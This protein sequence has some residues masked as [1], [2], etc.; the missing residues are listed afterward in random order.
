MTKRFGRLLTVAIAASLLTLASISVLITVRGIGP[1]QSLSVANCQPEHPTST[2]VQ[3][4]LN[5]NGGMMGGSAMMV[6]LNANVATVASGRVTFIATN[7]G[8]LNH[9]LLILPMPTGGAGTRP[10]GANGKIDE[11]SSLGEASQS[12]ATGVGNGISPGTR[13]WTTVNLVP[14]N[15]ELLCD[16]P[17]H[18]AN[19]MF[20][21]LTVR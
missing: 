17:W 16:V 11:S 13:S 8:H 15:Y 2:P 6:G 21:T 19:G 9:E 20:T 4:S 3:V 18:Y 10:L 14:G 5:D 12:C 7:Y 1:W